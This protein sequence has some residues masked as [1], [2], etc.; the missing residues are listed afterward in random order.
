MAS[1]YADYF[2]GGN[3]MFPMSRELT[4]PTLSPTEVDNRG[5][6]MFPIQ[7]TR[8]IKA[9]DTGTA[10][11]GNAT[12]MNQELSQHHTSKDFG[13]NGGPAGEFGQSKS[14]N[15]TDNT[16]TNINQPPTGH[17]PPNAHQ[18]EMLGRDASFSNNSQYDVGRTWNQSEGTNDYSRQSIDLDSGGVNTDISS[19]DLPGMTKEQFLARL[20]AR[21]D[22]TPQTSRSSP[23]TANRVSRERS[24]KGWSPRSRHSQ[25][26]ATTR[27]SQKAHSIVE[28]TRKCSTSGQLSTAENADIVDLFGSS[29]STV[30]DVS[31]SQRK[32]RRVEEGS[33]VNQLSDNDGPD[34]GE[35][36]IGFGTGN[37]TSTSPPHWRPR[38]TQSSHSDSQLRRRPSGR[39]NSIVTPPV[40]SPLPCSSTTRRNIG[41]GT[42]FNEIVKLRGMENYDAWSRAVRAAARK[43]GVWDMLTGQCMLPTPLP[44]N[45]SVAEQQEYQDNSVYWNNKKD[46]ALGGLEGSLEEHIQESVDIQADECPRAVWLRLEQKYKPIENKM[47]YTLV[48]RLDNMSLKYY[49]SVE[50]L[51]GELRQIQQKLESVKK[52]EGLPSWYFTIRFLHSLGMAYEEFVSGILAT[53][54]ALVRDKEPGNE[55][56]FEQIVSRAILEEQRLTLR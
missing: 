51:A 39:E 13:Y 42:A 43:E 3:S 50:R 30:S 31:E 11:S 17:P 37:Q 25:S 56:N 32:R 8:S 23:D 26:P 1:E 49:G 27:T 28:S 2:N 21:W 34:Y 5:N 18:L 38:S 40:L 19:N 44:P 52:S 12:P 9:I 16:P 15:A 4:M 22:H 36:N 10:N 35:S 7:D 41:T 55:L 29:Q 14:L 53:E 24:D 20:N 46:L 45:P 54:A 33:I 48:Q 6:F 47:V